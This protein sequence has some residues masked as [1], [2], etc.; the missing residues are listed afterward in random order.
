M[1]ADLLKQQF[2]SRLNPD[3]ESKIKPE[4]LAILD[5]TIESVLEGHSHID[6]KLPETADDYFIAIGYGLIT[7]INLFE[8]VLRPILDNP[9]KRVV[10][11]NYRGK[12][13]KYNNF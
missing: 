12:T 2:L 5:E 4:Y 3:F 7:R 6:E 13:F 8:S 1:T 11:V 10:E 9:E